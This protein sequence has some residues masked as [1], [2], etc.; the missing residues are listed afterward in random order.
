MASWVVEVYAWFTI[1]NFF[2]L[3]WPQRPPSERV[4]YISE[5]LDFWWSIPQKITSND[6]FGANDDQTIRIRRFF[7]GNWTLEAVE[8]SE[9][10]EATEVNDAG[11]VSKAWKI[12]TVDFRVFQVLEFNNFRTNI[13]LFWCFEKKIFLTESWKL[14]LNFSTFSVGGRWGCVR[15]KKILNDGSSINFPYLGSPRA[16]VLVDLSKHLVKP[17]LYFVSIP[18]GWPCR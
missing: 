16:S 12:T 13:T 4:P 11:E 9:L 8:A 3:M 7:W 1:W 10:T 2:D 5:K 18:N 14:M 15:S 6:Y 17:G